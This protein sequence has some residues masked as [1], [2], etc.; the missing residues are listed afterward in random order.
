M[1]IRKYVY[2]AGCPLRQ[3]NDFRCFDAMENRKGVYVFQS[4]S[5]GS[6]LYVGQAGARGDQKLKK[7]VRQHYGKGK[8]GANMSINW[9]KENCSRCKGE[10][11]CDETCDE[12]GAC[13][14]DSYKV[15]LRSCRVVFFCFDDEDATKEN[16]YALEKQL[17]F[18]FQPKYDDEIM[19]TRGGSFDEAEADEAIGFLLENGREPGEAPPIPEANRI[20]I[21]GDDAANNADRIDIDAAIC[22]GRPRIRGTRIRVSDILNLMAAGVSSAGILADYPSLSRDDLK[23]ALA[24]GAQASD[25]AGRGSA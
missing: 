6:V 17:K 8:T 12:R 14:F 25:R 1:G 22:G 5:D 9:R 3:G 13:A 24:F 4:E 2:D 7:R 15:L 20:D 16:I 18:A 10:S 19:K 11:S 21:G 23:A